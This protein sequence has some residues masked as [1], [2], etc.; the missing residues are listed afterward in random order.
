MSTMMNNGC[1]HWG[2]FFGEGLILVMLGVI[3]LMMPGKVSVL[4][5]LVLAWLLIIGGVVEFFMSFKNKRGSMLFLGILTAIVSVGCGIFLLNR[6]IAGTIT[7]TMIITIYLCVNGL[8]QVF[9]S[10]ALKPIKN[11]YW[12]LISGLVSIALAVLVWSAWP[13][14]FVAFLGIILGINF[15]MWGMSEIILSFSLRKAQHHKIPQPSSVQ[16]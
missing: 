11:W 4:L 14:S 3:A 2:W 15:I 7:I 6:P 16:G 8:M 9:Y 10:F 5:T 13:V 12:L 1:R